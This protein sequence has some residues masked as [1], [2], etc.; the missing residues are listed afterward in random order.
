[1]DV[2]NSEAALCLERLDALVGEKQDGASADCELGGEA[3]SAAEKAAN[4]DTLDAE[5][6]ETMELDAEEP[7]AE[8]LETEESDS[9]EFDIEE[10][11]TEE[12][13]IE[14]LDTEALD[15]EAHVAQTS[16]Y[17]EYADVIKLSKEGHG[18]EEIARQLK[19][20]K[21]EVSL[22]LSLGTV[23]Q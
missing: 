11:E 4:E 7:K 22:I 1:M 6:P 17:A 8:E 23:K 5:E 19:I 9:E 2:K 20:G 14:E 3:E 18:A 12:P 10:L 21:G 13:D 16:I 15:T